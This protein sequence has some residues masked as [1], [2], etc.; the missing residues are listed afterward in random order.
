[1][2]ERAKKL[3]LTVNLECQTPN[4]VTYRIGEHYSTIG[5]GINKQTA[6]QQA[7]EKMLE[8]LPDNDQQQKEPSNRKRNNQHKK[9]IQQKGS[10][11]YSWSDDINPITR[12]YQIAQARNVSIDFESFQKSESRQ[13]FQ[14]VVHYGDELTAEGM[15]Q[16]KQAA[17]RNAAQQ[18]LLQLYPDTNRIVKSPSTLSS[19]SVPGKSLLKREENSPKKI[20]KKHVH[21]RED[22]NGIAEKKTTRS[23]GISIREQLIKACNKLNIEIEYQD[24]SVS[25][26]PIEYQSLLSL[27]TG[28]RLLAKFRGLG[29]S[30]ERARENVSHAAWKNLR[31]LFNG[32]IPTPKSNV[33]TTYQ[34]ERFDL[35]K[36]E[37][38]E[39][40]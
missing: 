20:E 19:T 21:F 39:N 23:C 25:E 6:K 24:E 12:L 35:S 2:Y 29:P 5:T 15:G 32:S 36:E 14:S 37:N 27:S 13:V 8:I 26:E 30:L 18:M 33:K 22:E 3:S 10:V 1:M 4:Q 16:S 38:G 7:A 17:K 31:Q 11:D 40:K 34:R 28:D 9:F